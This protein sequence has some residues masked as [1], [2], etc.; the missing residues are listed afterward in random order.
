MGAADIKRVKD[1]MCVDPQGLNF[2]MLEELGATFE[3]AGKKS[4]AIDLYYMGLNSCDSDMCR[5]AMEK[6][7]RRAMG[8]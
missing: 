4:D 8:K 3:K 7:L 1:G 6:S 2:L 5:E